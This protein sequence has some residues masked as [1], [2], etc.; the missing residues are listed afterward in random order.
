MIVM[1]HV[2]NHGMGWFHTGTDSGFG[3]PQMAG[4][5]QHHM[6]GNVVAFEGPITVSREVRK[7]RMHE[8][9]VLPRPRLVMVE[10]H[11]D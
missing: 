1:M 5:V 4:E 8:L 7:D 2:C 9:A 6:V 3:S 10:S 11:L